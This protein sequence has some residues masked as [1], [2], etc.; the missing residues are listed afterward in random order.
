MCVLCEDELN[1]AE[2][3]FWNSEHGAQ[4]KAETQLEATQVPM[5]C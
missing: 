4:T 3:L 1:L 5:D 2:R